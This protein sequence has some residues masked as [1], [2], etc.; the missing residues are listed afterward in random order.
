VALDRTSDG[1]W[2]P[3]GP[4]LFAARAFAALGAR[5]SLV[6]N[7]EPGYDAAALSALDVRSDEGE[8]PRFANTYDSQ[9][10]RTQVLLAEG[11]RL[12]VAPHFR[13]F[14]HSDIVFI[15]P[16]YHEFGRSTL[17]F[18]SPIFGI[19]LQG[20]LRSVD[21][22]RRIV[23]HPDPLGVSGRFVRP[24]RLA[25]LSEEDTPQ[26]ERLAQHIAALGAVAI[27]TRGYNGA[28]LFDSDG[29]HHHWEALPASPV[30]PTG[31]GDCFASAFLFRLAES[32]ELASA[33]RFALA[34]GALAVEGRGLAGIANREAIESRM[35]RE[36]A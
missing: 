19:S 18:K 26:P 27:L 2:T 15:T 35:T 1:G 14:E 31:A 20:A 6:T 17:R 13:A 34:A 5:V 16:A 4:S 32:G 30:D 33:M 23:P 8:L 9:G 28:T 25:F 11:S 29:S 12:Q 10:H 24:G 21:A 7:L 36:A 22:A 3:G